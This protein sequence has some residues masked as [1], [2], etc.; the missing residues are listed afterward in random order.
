MFS[1]K[2]GSEHRFTAPEVS[3]VG[4]LVRKVNHTLWWTAVQG[5]S[6]RTVQS[7]V[8]EPFRNLMVY[9]VE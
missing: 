7:V 5:V 6:E 4:T 9:R 1:E 2:V 8:L 3:E